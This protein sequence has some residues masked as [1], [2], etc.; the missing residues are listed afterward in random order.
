MSRGPEIV[1]WGGF[2]AEQLQENNAKTKV[3]LL[4]PPINL[5]REGK[6]D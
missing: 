2:H 1:G 4:F 3:E 5:V 6:N